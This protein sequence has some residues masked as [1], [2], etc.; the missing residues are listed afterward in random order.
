MRS[1][2]EVTRTAIRSAAADTFCDRGYRA[3]T[4]EEI[5]ARVGITRGA[6]LHHFG[7]KADLLAAVAGP[8]LQA[9]SDLLD[10]RQVADPPT[11][12][13][14]RA[15]VTDITDLFLEHRMALRLL[16]NDVAARVELGSDGRW[17]AFRTRLVA[18]LFGDAATAS[19]RVSVSAALGA[20]CQPVAGSWLDLDDPRTRRELIGAAV[21]VIDGAEPVEGVA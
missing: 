13:Q 16:V 4:L 10:A 14:Q 1:T 2:A 15:V 12:T 17:D 21:G 5:G 7:S 8:F 18:L 3:A 6:V 19:E 11:S 9:L 20:L